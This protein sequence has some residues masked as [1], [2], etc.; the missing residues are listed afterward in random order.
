MKPVDDELHHNIQ[1]HNML[2]AP[3]LAQLH[4]A[5]EDRKGGRAVLVYKKFTTAF[6]LLIKIKFYII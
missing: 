3:D 1:M 2:D 5:V 6:I 4:Q